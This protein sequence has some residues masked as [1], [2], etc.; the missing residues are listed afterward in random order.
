[1]MLAIVRCFHSNHSF[2]DKFLTLALGLRCVK[3]DITRGPKLRTLKT[4]I[5]TW[6]ASD[7]PRICV[8][9]VSLPAWKNPLFMINQ[10]VS[11]FEQWHCWRVQ[12]LGADECSDQ[13]NQYYS[14]SITIAFH[15]R[16]INHRPILRNTASNWCICLRRFIEKVSSLRM[17]GFAIAFNC[18][19]AGKT[20]AFFWLVLKSVLNALH[21][22]HRYQ[23]NYFFSECIL[24]KRKSNEKVFRNTHLSDAIIEFHTLA[25]SIICDRLKIL[26][27]KN[28]QKK[29]NIFLRQIEIR[30]DETDKRL[31]S[32]SSLC[33][34][35]YVCVFRICLR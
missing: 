13:R 1:M 2:Y 9:A 23:I 28:Q 7:W 15:R 24:Y 33:E 14:S 16:K 19:C 34:F 35:V 12:R 20:L 10:S 4:K 11:R 17:M 6:H 18:S 22:F 32:I 26:A 30:A 25:S 3:I 8:H 21:E 29:R 27:V 5:K 31:S